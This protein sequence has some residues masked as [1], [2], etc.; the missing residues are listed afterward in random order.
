[1]NPVHSDDR[2]TPVYRSVEAL[3]LELG[4][5]RQSAYSALRNGLIPSIRLGK[6]YILPRA[7]TSRWLAEA[8]LPKS[9]D[10]GTTHA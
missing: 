1:M 10:R 6:R 5:S 8:G 9:D 2:A 4:I 3:A 7:A